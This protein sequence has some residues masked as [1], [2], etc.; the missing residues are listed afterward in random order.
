[1]DT[2]SSGSIPQLLC[3]LVLAHRSKVCCGSRHLQEPLR[4]SDGVLRGSSSNVLDIFL[5]CQVLKPE[6]T[7]SCIAADEDIAIA[8]LRRAGNMHTSNTIGVRRHLKKREVRVIRQ[9]LVCELDLQTPH[10]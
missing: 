4:C 7:Q 2:P 3:I 1:M 8:C 10:A 5:R 6:I 9:D